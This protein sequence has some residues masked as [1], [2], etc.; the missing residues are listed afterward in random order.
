MGVLPKLCTSKEIKYQRKQF[1]ETL[2][3]QG[4]QVRLYPIKRV[5]GEDVYDF[6]NDVREQDLSYDDPIDIRILFEEV[7][8]MRTLKSLGWFIDDNHLPYIAYIPTEYL[9]MES[10][11]HILVPAV[12]DKIMLLDSTVEGIRSVRSYRIKDMRSMGYPDTIY[13]VAKLAPV[14]END[15]SDVFLN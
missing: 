5:E 11:E 12:D 6:Y 3:V 9:D 2:D 1:Q 8:Q 10:K 15:P 4:V 13:H 14:R 7:P